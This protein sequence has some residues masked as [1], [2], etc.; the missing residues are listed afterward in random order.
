MTLQA[1]KRH[2]DDNVDKHQAV[3]ERIQQDVEKAKAKYEEEMKKNQ[4]SSTSGG[5]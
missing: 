5:N 3:F 2:H 4:T 1:R